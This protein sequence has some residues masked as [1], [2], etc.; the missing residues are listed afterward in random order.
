MIPVYE[1]EKELGLEESIQASASFSL[2]GDAVLSEPTES[3]RTFAELLTAEAN[4]DQLDLYYI[5]SVLVSV[6][7]NRNDDVFPYID[8][9]NARN[10]PVD[11]PFNYMHDMSDIIGHITSSVVVDHDGNV[12]GHDTPLDDVPEVFDI[13]VGS[14][15]YKKW[16]DEEA[17]ARMDRIIAEIPTGKWKVSMECLFNNFD[18]AVVSPA[19]E[20]KVIKRTEASAFLTKH[21][22]V[23]GGKGEYEGYRVGR[24]LRNFAFSGKGLVD[25]PANPRSDVVGYSDK[26]ETNLFVCASE[27][28]VNELLKEDESDMSVTY[29]QEQYDFLKE[30]LDGVKATVTERD[31]TIVDLKS[32]IAKLKEESDKIEVKVQETH[33]SALQDK[34]EQIADLTTKLEKASA[35]LEESNK[36]LEDIEAE[37]AKA[38]RL[39]RIMERDVTEEKAKSLIE[40]FADVS[41]EMFD[42][43]VAALPEK[44]QADETEEET[45]EGDEE[46]VEAEET[47]E[48][49]EVDD[50]DS[51]DAANASD[52]DSEDKLFKSVASWIGGTLRSTAKLEN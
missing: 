30:E 31:K 37:A 45:S 41:D 43:L 34:D 5:R 17:Q 21:L 38:A 35:D 1:A 40:K 19:G 22:K 8:T 23:F 11:K 46:V 4:P 13:V 2:L 27:A 47:L 7:W 14:V 36:K 29:T 3:Q 28:Q 16:P 42:E 10:T 25:K 48:D 18:Y 26:T 51:S 6:G 9:W 44:V 33:A 20:N 12:I 50:D 39:T 49:S 24:L 32:E 15:L 52:D